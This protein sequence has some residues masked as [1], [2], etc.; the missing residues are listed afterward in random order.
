[1]TPRS[2]IVSIHDVSPMTRNAVSFILAALGRIGIRRTSLLVIPDHHRHGNI[3]ADADFTSWLRDLVAAGHEPVL[4]G[5]YHQRDRHARE[6]VRTRFFTRLYTANEGEFFDIAFRDARDLLTRGR[7]DLGQCANA[8]PAGFIAPAWLLSPAGEEA[9]RDLGFEY[10]TRLKTISDLATRR[11][12][13]SQSLCWSVRS[14]SR[15]FV[16]LGWNAYLR[17]SV[18]MNSVFRISIHPPDITH[19]DIWYQIQHFAAKALEGREPITYNDFITCR[20][21]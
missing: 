8:L 6:S 13:H 14:R 10:T 11:R 18:R 21:N 16:S 2:L 19:P 20:R 5:F 1:M 7:D 9:A 15:R 4:H 17:Q 12:F 3:T